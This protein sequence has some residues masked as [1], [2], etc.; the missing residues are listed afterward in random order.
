[1]VVRQS[2]HH[3]LCLCDRHI[4]PLKPDHVVCGKKKGFTHIKDN[5]ETHMRVVTVW[6]HLWSS[7]SLSRVKDIVFGMPK[8]LDSHDYKHE[9]SGGWILKGRHSFLLHPQSKCHILCYNRYITGVQVDTQLLKL[10]T[11]F[12]QQ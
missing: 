1:M 9:G 12:K 2:F 4:N 6:G 5:S 11:N 10:L 8:Q 3:L 7:V